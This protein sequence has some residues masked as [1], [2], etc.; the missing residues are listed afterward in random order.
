MPGFARTFALERFVSVDLV[1]GDLQ[2]NVPPA[3]WLCFRVTGR[4]RYLRMQWARLI[5]SKAATIL[6]D[7][8][9]IGET[10]GRELTIP[11]TKHHR[12]SIRDIGWL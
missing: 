7:F 11:F 9:A 10:I 3:V 6:A 8:E 1:T 12:A 5:E 4:K 2:S